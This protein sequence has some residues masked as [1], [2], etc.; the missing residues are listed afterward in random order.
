MS[1]NKKRHIDL[2][3]TG[4]QNAIEVLV[5]RLNKLPFQKMEMFVCFQCKKLI[6]GEKA[7]YLDTSVKFGEERAFCKKCTK[8]CD[9]C[10]D[11]YC[12]QLN[13]QHGKDICDQSSSEESS[14]VYHNNHVEE[15]HKQDSN[16]DDEDDDDED[17]EWEF[18]EN[19]DDD[20]E[21]DED[22]EDDEDD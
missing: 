17:D 11:D 9:K 6:Y 10:D 5:E 19:Q 15:K 1:N 12:E 13:D 16:K 21:N 3:E 22:D 4:N 7:N 2:E 20:D 14:E 8:H 18:D